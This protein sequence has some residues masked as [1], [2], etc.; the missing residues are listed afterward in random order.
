V[1]R[2]A[3]LRPEEAGFPGGDARRVP[4]LRRGEVA[5][6]AGVSVEYFAK[7]ERGDLA[8]ASESVL[9]SIARALRL[10]DAERAHLFDLA[11]TAAG[12][13]RPRAR[14]KRRAW[15]TRTSL[16]LV[17]D[18]ITGGPAFVRNGRMDIVATNALGRAFFEEAFDGPG[19]GNIARFA[20]LDAR[21]TSFYPEWEAAA[22]IIVGILR[23][24]AGRD[25]YDKDLHDLVGHLSTVSDAFRVRWGAHDVRRHSNGVKRFHHH[26]VGDLTLL[27][28]DLEMHADP[29]HTLLVYTA[30]PG[31]PSAERLQLLA[32]LAA[33]RRS[34][35]AAT[36]STDHGP[37]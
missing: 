26:S 16:Q 33:T 4:G 19:A 1:S 17:L 24:A 22:D 8:G 20:F 5:M 14:G 10:D 31:T 28:E 27:Y 37:S 32:S 21:A 13:E 11:R 7:I 18:A 34:D 15:T 12:S 6:L 29:Q 36:A 35:P 9:E 30:E 3:K 23:T 2:R 25:P